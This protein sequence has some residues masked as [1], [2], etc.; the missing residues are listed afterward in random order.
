MTQQP[1]FDIEHLHG[2]LCHSRAF[3]EGEPDEHKLG[4]KLQEQCQRLP[5]IARISVKGFEDVVFDGEGR[6]I[7]I[8]PIDAPH[9]AR[10][11]SKMSGSYWTVI[12]ILRTYEGAT[13]NDIEL[14]GVVPLH[15]KANQPLLAW[16]SGD[17]CHSQWDTDEPMCTA[18]ETKLDLRNQLITANTFHPSTRKKLLDLFGDEIANIEDYGSPAFNMLVVAFGGAQAFLCYQQDHYQL[19][20]AYLFT[21]AAGGLALDWD[22]QDLGPRHF[23]FDNKTPVILAA[24]GQIA[25]DVLRRMVQAWPPAMP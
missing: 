23:Q 17:K 22:G 9:H 16:R 4:K 18:R 12:T 8:D 15:W 24:N 1:L 3:H 11:R 25:H 20:A 5:G 6:W 2:L 21:K 13:F 7:C 14:A 19:G 10:R